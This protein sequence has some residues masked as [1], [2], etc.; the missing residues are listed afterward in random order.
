MIYLKNFKL[1]S[2]IDEH[3]IEDPRRIFNNYYPLNIFWRKGLQKLEFSKITIICGSNGSGKSTLLNIIAEKIG[4]IRKS[5][6]DKGSYFSL[7]ANSCKFEMSFEMPTEIKVLT[8][9]DIFD[10]LLNIRSI[11]SG[12]NNRKEYLT[13]EWLN[14]KYNKENN[15]IKN[16]EEIKRVSDAKNKTMSKFIRQH[17][18]NNNIIEQSN[19]E[20]SLLFF[21]NE[22]KENAIYILDEPENSLSAENQLKLKKFIEDSA[23]FYNCQFII[24]THSPFLLSLNDALIYDL[25]S[26]P[27]NVKKWTEINSVKTYYDFFQSK[28]DE[29]ENQ[30]ETK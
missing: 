2:E 1:L 27:V 4:A 19:G 10:Y 22:I 24:S 18:G 5:K 7:Y 12:V 15:S 6:I 13:N 23:R 25:D 20:S 16:Y 26:D 21:E 9:D 3:N 8:S 29:F 11:N 28:K 14:L 30:L 17:L